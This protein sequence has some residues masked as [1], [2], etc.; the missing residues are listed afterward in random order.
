MRTVQCYDIFASVIRNSSHVLLRNMINDQ[1]VK[2]RFSFPKLIR[3]NFKNHHIRPL[4]SDDSY[5]YTDV[6]IYRI[7]CI[8]I[9]D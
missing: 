6:D 1:I 3:T 8:V 7:S 5:V 4:I 2:S 9:D